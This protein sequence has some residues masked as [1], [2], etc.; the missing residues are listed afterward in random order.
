M[1]HDLIRLALALIAAAVLAGC[2]GGSAGD[3]PSVTSIGA[4]N[5]RYGST[6][7][8]IVG[9]RN[10]RNGARVV[11]EGPCEN[12]APVLGATQ[13]TMRYSCDV[14][15]LGQIRARVLDDND[16]G[17]ALLTLTIPTP[18]VEINTTQGAFTLE[19]DPV[20]APLTVRN[21]LTYVNS[22]FY[23]NLLFHR[24]LKDRLIQTGAFA[25]GLTTPVSTIRSPIT[26]ES[27]NGLKNLRA[28]IAMARTAGAPNSATSQ[29]YVNV[30]DNPD[31]DFVDEANPGF[32]VFGRVIGGM[33]TVDTISAVDVRP[34]LAR[35]LGEVPVTE[36]SITAA[37]Q[38][39]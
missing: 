20:A 2:S 38:I 16:Q 5:A 32:A 25:S 34:D 15:G 9:G 14:R 8:I 17:L 21:F 31:F 10:L 18:Q 30:A 36:I 7:E 4:T 28:T 13:D 27:N 33:A 24:A 6:T 23:R 3:A 39:R 12:L 35:G 37:T 29:W 1:T 11:V 26:L 22:G 19:L